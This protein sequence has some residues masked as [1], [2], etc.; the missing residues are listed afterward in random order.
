MYNDVIMWGEVR[1]S[2]DVATSKCTLVVFSYG[3]VFLSRAPLS[4]SHLVGVRDESSALAGVK[5]SG[6]VNKNNGAFVMALQPQI[7]MAEEKVSSTFVSSCSTSGLA[8][9]R[10]FSCKF[11]GTAFSGRAELESHKRSHN[12]NLGFRCLDCNFSASTWFAVREHMGQHADLR[13]HKCSQC[14]FASKNKKDLR[15][16]LLTHT[17]EKPFSCHVCGQRFNRNGH[18]KLHMDRLHCSETHKDCT[19]ST[20]LSSKADGTSSSS[21]DLVVPTSE[22]IMLGLVPGAIDQEQATYIEHVTA[23]GETFQQVIATTDEMGHVQYLISQDG[24]PQEYIV[25][26]PEGHQLQLLQDGHIQDGELQLQQIE[27]EQNEATQHL[28]HEQVAVLEAQ[29]A[30]SP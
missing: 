30:T 11:C 5:F 20:S 13:P 14:S 23:D 4:F 25:E 26:L 17:N 1:I 22:Q 12:G 6:S 16:H 28:L 18:L 7:Q 10:R 21:G 15:R 9:L 3:P 8:S 19:E 2:V 24:V 29:A 27:Y